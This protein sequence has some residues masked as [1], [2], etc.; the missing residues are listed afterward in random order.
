M[1]CPPAGAKYP[2]FKAP[3]MDYKQR[4]HV[5]VVSNFHPGLKKVSIIW[6]I[7]NFHPGLKFD[8]GLV[9]PSSNFNSVCRVEVFTCNCNVILKRCLLSSRD[10]IPARFNELK[11]QPGLKVSI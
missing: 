6:K 7:W 8:L 3:L 4:I 5:C 2:F 10:E 9:K 1:F 11:F